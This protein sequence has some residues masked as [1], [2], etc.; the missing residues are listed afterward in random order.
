MSANHRVQWSGLPNIFN[1]TSFS[2]DQHNTKLHGGLGLIILNDQ[3][4]TSLKNIR[5]SGIYS[6]EIIFSKNFHMRTGFEASLWQNKLFFDQLTF[7]DNIDPLRGFVNPSSIV[8]YNDSKSGLDFSSGVLAYN[9]KLF[10]GISAHH[11]TQ[12]N[13]SNLTDA[14]KLLRKYTFNMG[15]HIRILNNQSKIDHNPLIISPNIIWKR[16]GESRQLNMGLY[17]EKGSYVTGFWFRDNQNCSLILGGKV[18]Q[19]NIG[20]SYGINFSRL[21]VATSGSHEVSIQINLNC[22]NKN[23]LY[24]TLSCPSF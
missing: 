17:L 6:Y 2:Y 13:Q 1:T 16:Q 18:G 9:S 24:N 15:Y 23:K 20:Y 19:L 5:L 10:F 12:P 21:Q 22:D 4:S 11:L 8:G 14:A 7:I 3:L